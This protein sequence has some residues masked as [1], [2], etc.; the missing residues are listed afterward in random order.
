[1]IEILQIAILMF[2]TEEPSETKAA[3][4]NSKLC[5][6]KLKIA[7]NLTTQHWKVETIVK[8]NNFIE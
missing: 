3:E 7:E 1:M 4:V 5:F 8:T 2:S 6:L